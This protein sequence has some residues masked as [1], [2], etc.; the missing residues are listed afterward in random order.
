MA[1]G[2]VAPVL[3]P[4]TD[5]VEVYL[6]AGLGPPLDGRQIRSPDRGAY[7]TVSAPIGEPAVFLEEDLRRDVFRGRAR[8]GG[9]L[10]G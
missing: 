2:L 8:R 4:G 1:P 3:D 6:P 10:R 5:T 7:E 9:L